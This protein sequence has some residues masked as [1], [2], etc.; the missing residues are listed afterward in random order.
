MPFLSLTS[1]AIDFPVF[2]HFA[3]SLKRTLAS[4]VTGGAI[5]TETGVTT[6]HALADVT[7]RIVQGERVGIMGH[8]GSGK[9][10]L[11]RTLAGVY[12]PTRG[13]FTCGGTVSSLIDPSLGIEPELNG[14]EN[15]E[16]RG[17]LIGLPRHVVK[18][19]MPDIEAFSELG[20]Y[21]AMPLR[22]YSTGML[23]R[24]VFAIATAMRAD[25]LLM[26]EWLSV[27][28]ADFRDKAEQRLRDV[29]QES[30]ILVLASHSEELIKK[31]CNRIVVLEHGRIVRDEPL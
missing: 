7:L 3:H 28:D 23:M 4:S 10:T 16:L 8:N 1:V 6:V 24:L 12:P 27:G 29:V 2:G 17:A 22:T 26:D 13:M 19:L 9:T 15:V 14:Y 5:G 31:E 25:I 21:L 30:G 20:Q 18:G 11:L